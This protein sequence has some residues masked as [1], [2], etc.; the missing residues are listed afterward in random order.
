MKIIIIKF[1]YYSENV[2]V[3]G[4]SR[5]KYGITARRASKTWSRVGRN[6]MSTNLLLFGIRDTDKKPWLS[7]LG[8]P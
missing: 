2:L 6:C 1:I 7:K 8:L 4:I 5:K 3:Y